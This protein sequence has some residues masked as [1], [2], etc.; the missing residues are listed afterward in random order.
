[1]Y[2][3]YRSGGIRKFNLPW[4]RA[5]DLGLA[6]DVSFWQASSGVT[7]ESTDTNPKQFISL[8]ASRIPLGDIGVLY[9]VADDENLYRFS[10]DGTPDQKIDLDLP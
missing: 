5:E 3:S 10:A 7:L 1:M 2:M 9:A 4:K 8:Y 6:E